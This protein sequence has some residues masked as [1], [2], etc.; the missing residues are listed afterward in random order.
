MELLA[1]LEASGPAAALRT[2]RWLYPLVNAG[3]I[4][5]LGLLFGAIVPLDLRL[6][7]LWRSVPARALAR[8]L[9]PVAATGVGLAV[10]T[11][12]LLFSVRPLDYAPAGLFQ[13]KLAVVLLALANVALLHRLPAWR[14]LGDGPSGRALPLAAALSLAL[15]LTAILLGRLLAYR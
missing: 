5:G 12:L 7:G 2:S 13:A 9:V 4:L 14:R 10:V 11:G 1:A 3:H 8:V 6:L 15:W